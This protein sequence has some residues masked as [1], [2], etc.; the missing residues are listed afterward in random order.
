M[1]AAR[2]DDDNA[3]REL[4][5]QAAQVQAHHH[6]GEPDDV[7]AFG[8]E[9]VR[10]FPR[11]TVAIYQGNIVAGCVISFYYVTANYVVVFGGSSPLDVFHEVFLDET[12]PSSLADKIV[13]VA[14]TVRLVSYISR[15]PMWFYLYNAYLWAGRGRTPGEVAR[16]MTWV[17]GTWP[18]KAN[19]TMGK[20][21]MYWLFAV[22]VMVMFAGWASPDTG[23]DAQGL[24]S[25][26]S[27]PAPL[28]CDMAEPDEPVGLLWILM[29]HFTGALSQCWDICWGVLQWV[30]DRLGPLGCGDELYVPFGAESARYCFRSFFFARLLLLFGNRWS[31]CLMNL[32]VVVLPPI[33]SALC[34]TH[35]VTNGDLN[36]V[37][38][39]LLD[40]V[41]I[42]PRVA[43]N[44]TVRRLPYVKENVFL[45]RCGQVS[46]QH[47]LTVANFVSGALPRRGLLH[48]SPSHTFVVVPLQDKTVAE[49]KLEPECVICR[50]DIAAGDTLRSLPCGTKRELAIVMRVGFASFSETSCWVAALCAQCILL[51][52][53]AYF[54]PHCLCGRVVFVIIASHVPDV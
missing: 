30:G 7:D 53:R 21:F 41:C 24:Q 11:E 46:T 42:A 49:L 35:M 33:V 38:S 4:A 50:D 15:V 43:S 16:R 39:S 8:G 48:E 51:T 2:A 5:A 37:P 1:A 32:S 12:N 14:T 3:V 52:Y 26:L 10:Q 19:N 22:L 17:N 34:F 28:A 13:L 18:S 20:V 6:V 31:L 40:E 47:V 36:R 27:E 23:P 9:M 25:E 45:S 29:S 54:V 44:T